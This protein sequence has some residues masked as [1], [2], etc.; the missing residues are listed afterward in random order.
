M[1][2]RAEHQGGR[3]PGVARVLPGGVSCQGVR[4][5][6]VRESFSEVVSFDRDFFRIEGNRVFD[7]RFSV[8]R[9]RSGLR[10]PAP[11]PRRK[12]PSPIIVPPWS[13]VSREVVTRS[14]S[15]HHNG[16]ATAQGLGIGLSGPGQPRSAPFTWTTRIPYYLTPYPHMVQV[17]QVVQVKSQIVWGIRLGR[18]SPGERGV[19]KHI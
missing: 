4:G 3:V 6:P 5:A 15:S 7:P 12:D 17:V 19:K 2:G 13:L 16:R 8:R 9:E 1:P 14:R 18:T 10:A 11:R